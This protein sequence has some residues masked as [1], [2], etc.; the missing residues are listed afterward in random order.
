MNPEIESLLTPVFLINKDLMAAMRG[1]RAPITTSEARFLI[2]TFYLMQDQRIRANNQIKGLE[3]AATKTASEADPHDAMDWTHTQFHTLE[4]QVE[5]ILTIF[6][7]SHP[8]WPFFEATLGVGPVLASGLLAHID[9]TQSPTAGHIWR[10]AGLDPTQKWDKKTKR[11]W[12]AALKKICWKIGDSFVK[13]S[14]NPRSYYGPLYRERKRYEWQ[15]NLDG[16]NRDQAGAYL[17]QKKYASTTDAHAWYS[18]QCDPD[19]A[20]SWLEQDKAPTAAACRAQ[21]GQG[22]PM[23]TPAQIDMRARRYAVKLFLS[24]L[25]HCWWQHTYGTPPPHPYAISHLGHGH[26]LPPP[27]MR[28]DNDT[29]LH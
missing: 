1:N 12:N 16:T 29:T 19:L 6:A 21:D 4:Q 24:H 10:F 3:R 15:R 5:K 28:Q 7:T 22:V 13:S 14:S 26:Y 17:T 9:I 23:L 8:M 25:Q 27:Q 20:R 2:D 18:G 11:P